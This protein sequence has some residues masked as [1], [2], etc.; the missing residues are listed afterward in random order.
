MISYLIE[1]S[2]AWS[3]GILPDFSPDAV[4][5]DHPPHPAI[6]TSVCESRRGEGREE[7]RPIA[8]EKDRL[9]QMPQRGWQY[10]GH[11]ASEWS[12]QRYPWHPGHFSRNLRTREEDRLTFWDSEG[13]TCSEVTIL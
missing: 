4:N 13:V 6:M 12:G 9:A 7:T 2:Q 11:L 10:V 1:I 8:S 5:N 3:P